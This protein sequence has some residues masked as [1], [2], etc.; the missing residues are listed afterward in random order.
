MVLDQGSELSTSMMIPQMTA[1]ADLTRTEGELSLI[2][3]YAVG[4]SPWASQCA[5]VAL[6]EGLCPLSVRS[7][8]AWPCNP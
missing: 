7:D 6:G 5:H 2:P 3:D 1:T 4:N 8:M